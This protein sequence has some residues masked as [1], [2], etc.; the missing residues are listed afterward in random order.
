MTAARDL[1]LILGAMALVLAAAFYREVADAA[2]EAR[3]WWRSRRHPGPVASD[4]TVTDE[5]IWANSLE[6]GQLERR[7]RWY[8]RLAAK[9]K[10]RGERLVRARAVRGVLVR[11]RKSDAADAK[12]VNER[13]RP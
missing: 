3:E 12:F 7:N 4:V 10:L 5:Q 13:T 8:R 6:L 2:R 11:R 9:G 1:V